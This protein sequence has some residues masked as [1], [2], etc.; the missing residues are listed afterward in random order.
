MTVEKLFCIRQASGY[1]LGKN[2]MF[3]AERAK[4]LVHCLQNHH[5]FKVFL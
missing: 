1:I 3:L 2:F 5:L 4:T